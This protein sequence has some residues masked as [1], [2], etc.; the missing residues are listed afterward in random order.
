M[1][2]DLYTTSKYLIRKYKIQIQIPFQ[3]LL[4]Y[5]DFYLDDISMP[6]F[7]RSSLYRQP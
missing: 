7:D 1:Y 3:Q 5:Q 4:R 2:N 6:I